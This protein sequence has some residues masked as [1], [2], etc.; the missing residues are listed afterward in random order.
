[1]LFRVAVFYGNDEVLDCE[2]LSAPPSFPRKWESEMKSNRNLSDD[3]RL[4][5]IYLLDKKNLA[6]NHVQLINQF[7]Q[8]GTH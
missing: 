4:K 8:T 2:N 1:M 7:E 3:G 6:R 5:N